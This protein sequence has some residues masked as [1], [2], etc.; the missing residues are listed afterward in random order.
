MRVLMTGHRGYLGAEMVPVLRQLG[1]D[2]VGLDTD[3]YAGRDFLRSPDPVPMLAMDIRD[4]SARELRGFDAV[5]HLAALS[6]DPVSAL[7]PQLTYDINL[8][9]SVSLAE[10]AKA[11]GVT[12][13]VF[14]SSCSLYGRGG[15]KALSE[16]APLNPVTPYGESK[17][18]VERALSALAD[19]TFSPTYLRNATAYG[20][21]RRLRED[22][23]VNNL[24]GHAMTSGRVLLLSDGQSWR[25][26]VHVLDIAH[27]FAQTLAAPRESVHDE[28]FNVGRSTENYRIADVAK[29]VAELVPDCVVTCGEH[30]APDIRN[31]LVDF[32]KIE[33]QLPGYRPTWTVP[34]G[35]TQLRDAFSAGNMTAELFDG[36]DYVRLRT[37]QQLIEKGLLDDELRWN[38]RDEESPE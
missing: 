4:V 12:R 36:P 38:R 31:Y 8:H 5:V 11:A 9:A 18:Q 32:T 22:V 25:P 7:N 21:S 14:S 24:V 30:A 19:D 15:D 37:L 23:V 1:H 29:L 6:N 17:I 27:A 35:I 3:Y 16:L 33:T 10:A 28:A 26:L 2:V 20:L 34:A 13:F